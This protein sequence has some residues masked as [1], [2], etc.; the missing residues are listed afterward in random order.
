MLHYQIFPERSRADG[1]D[2]VEF[3]RR[4]W[5]Y[6]RRRLKRQTV[7]FTNREVA[8]I[9]G[10]PKG[11]VDSALSNLSRRLAQ[12]GLREIGSRHGHHDTTGIE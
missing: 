8:T 11:S 9:L 12:R 3:H 7:H 1:F 10:V 4:R 5:C 2:H 6:Y